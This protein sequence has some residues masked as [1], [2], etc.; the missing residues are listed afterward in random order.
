MRHSWVLWGVLLRLAARRDQYQDFL[1][2]IR[3]DDPEAYELFMNAGSEA[4]TS[5]DE[6]AIVSFVYGFARGV[7]RSTSPDAVKTWKDEA[8][9]KRCA[10]WFLDREHFLCLVQRAGK[11]A[12]N[13][14]EWVLDR[15]HT[16]LDAWYYEEVEHAASEWKVAGE[17]R[18]AV[19]RAQVTDDSPQV[20][21]ELEEQH[22]QQGHERAPPSTLHGV[23]PDDSS[24][25]APVTEEQQE[26]ES[27]HRPHNV[28]Y[29]EQIRNLFGVR[30]TQNTLSL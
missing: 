18:E 14:K 19:L 2:G 22:D 9:R 21:P 1:R 12:K 24:H 11:G 20:E 23:G 13:W 29:P 16:R 27:A 5:K 30:I 10:D 4:P 26:Q 3:D 17:R 6:D 15:W 8:A 7:A 25:G 28:G